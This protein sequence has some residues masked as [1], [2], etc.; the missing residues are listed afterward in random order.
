M[1]TRTKKLPRVRNADRP[2]AEEVVRKSGGSDLQNGWLSRHGTLSITDERLLFSPTI[3]DRV[4]GAKRREIL[5]D[6]IEELERF[7]LSPE[8][9]PPG[10]KRPRLLVHT[11]ACTYEFMVGDLDSW[12]DGILRVFELRRQAGRPHTPGVLREGYRDML[13]AEE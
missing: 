5:L 1:A 3:L 10:G 4:L 7:P 11:G 8:H 13:Y 9:F 6:E 2:R 12:I